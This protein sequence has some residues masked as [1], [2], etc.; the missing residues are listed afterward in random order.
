MLNLR[1]DK[2]L[3]PTLIWIGA[4]ILAAGPLMWLFE[5]WRDPAYASQG[6]M[7]ALA[8][9][10]L[11]IYTLS[12]ERRLEL[13]HGRRLGLLVITLSAVF[14]LASQL[15]GVNVLGALTL[16]V[17][18]YGIALLTGMHLRR[19]AVSPFWLA[20]LFM[21]ALPVERIAQRVVGFQ[22]QRVSA[23]GACALLN[24]GGP[25]ASCDGVEILLNGV[26]VL[27]DLP[28]AGARALTLLLALFALLAALRRPSAGVAAGGVILTLCSALFANVVRICTLAVGVAYPERLGSIDFTAAPWHELVGLWTLVLGVT[29]IFLWYQWSNAAPVRLRTPAGRCTP[30]SSP[31]IRPLAAAGLLIVA[32]AVVLAPTHPLD[33][34]RDMTPPSLPRVVNGQVGESLALNPQEARYFSVYGG[35]AARTRYGE[36]VLLTVSTTSPLRHLHAPDECLAGAGHRVRYLGKTEGTLTSAVYKSVDPNGRK[37]RVNVTFISNKGHMTTNVAHA[38]WLWLQDRELEWTMLQRIAPW[39]LALEA[40]AR[41]DQALARVFDLPITYQL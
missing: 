10:A 11:V 12:S 6:Y 17:D 16:T 3:A 19:R 27:V 35:G 34:S 4:S 22:L 14:R 7:M 21:F 20:A 26:N 30:Q 2:G 9:C 1:I 29:P 18:L 15:L 38:V 32:L 31:T 39:S 23:E 8:V 5:T 36:H 37:W 24:L 41:F 28:C 40:D 33:V 25:R 13:A